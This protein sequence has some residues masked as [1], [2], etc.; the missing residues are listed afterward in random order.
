MGLFTKQKL[1]KIR[2]TIININLSRMS[3]IRLPT[4]YFHILNC[5]KTKLIFYR[6]H[7]YL[8]T[9]FVQSFSKFHNIIWLYLEKILKNMI[10]IFRKQAFGFE[11]N[12]LF[13]LHQFWSEIKIKISFF[14]LFNYDYRIFKKILYS[15]AEV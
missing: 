11:I 9:L 12:A 13:T 7:L 1:S 15:F 10:Y 3:S 6:V 14:T 2:L 4:T 8:Y 5:L